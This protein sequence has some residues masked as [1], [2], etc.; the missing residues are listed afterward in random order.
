MK[1]NVLFIGAPGS[2]KGTQASKLVSDFGYKHL[3]TGDL[4]RA[5]IKKASELGLRVKAVMDAG[6]LVDDQLV[7]ELL[8]VNVDLNNGSYIF[9][10]FPR[11][12][13]Q[14]KMLDEELLGNSDYL[15]YY[16]D[17][18]LEELVT[19]LCFR[20]TCPSCGK[21]YNTKLMPPKQP[22]TCDACGHCGLVH[23]ADDT[24]IV[25]RE[26]LNVFTN[27]TVPVLDYYSAKG[28][29]RKVDATLATQDVFKLIVDSK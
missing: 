4:L 19:R 2:G 26:R 22:G 24:E 14:A 10:G 18:G 13:I 29:L 28:R 12:T 23:R 11:N 3:S 17:I 5:E 9:D 27:Q 7:L 20:E 6:K 25:V 8:K 1:K 16:F 15:V 21:I